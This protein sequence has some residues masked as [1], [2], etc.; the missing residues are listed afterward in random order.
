MWGVRVRVG[1]RLVRMPG[2]RAGARGRLAGMLGVR[3]PVGQDARSA[4][5]FCEL[6]TGS[7]ECERVFSARGLADKPCKPFTCGFLAC[8]AGASRELARTPRLLSRASE[9]RSHSSHPVPRLE[10]MARTPRFLSRGR[11][12]GPAF[13]GFCSADGLV[14]LL[15][16][17]SPRGSGLVGSRPASGPRLALGSAALPASRPGRLALPLPHALA[18]ALRVSCRAPC[19]FRADLG[20]RLEKPCR[21][22]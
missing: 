17:V 18:V 5:G 20:R 4:S 21:G 11:R 3:V 9:K 15:S 16:R 12:G 14:G 2:V 10:R 19:V 22:A 13:L 1:A 8:V 7:Q 6:G